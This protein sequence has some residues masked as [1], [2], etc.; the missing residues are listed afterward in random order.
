[1]TRG[2]VSSRIVAHTG[3]CG[4]APPLI[5]HPGGRVVKSL[6]R[7]LSVLAVAMLL[8]GVVLS[9]ETPA[10]KKPED[11]KPED[12]KPE[13]KKPVEKKPAE[14]KPAAKKPADP[15]AFPDTVELTD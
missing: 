2:T 4:P 1:M 14:K 13:E 3:P 15:F 7:Y 5:S 11:K 9:D 8:G 10:A 6:V 12:K